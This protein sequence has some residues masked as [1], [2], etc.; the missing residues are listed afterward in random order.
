MQ[1]DQVIKATR[2][3]YHL[4]SMN[5]IGV[6]VSYIGENYRW[7]KYEIDKVA[8][9][10]IDLSS[11]WSPKESQM[12]LV[13]YGDP[14]LTYL[15]AHGYPYAPI[16]GNSDVDRFITQ[17]A[18]WWY[19]AE[20]GI[21]SLSNSFISEAPDSYGLRFH[22]RRLVDAARDMRNMNVGSVYTIGDKPLMACVFADN[23]STTPHII[24]L[25]CPNEYARN[26]VSGVEAIDLASELTSSGSMQSSLSFNKQHH[27]SLNVA[28]GNFIITHDDGRYHIALGGVGLSN[29]QLKNLVDRQIELG[30]LPV[31]VEL[32]AS[33][34]P[35]APTREML[36]VGS[37][38]T[39]HDTNASAGLMIGKAINA[40]S[41]SPQSLE[42]NCSSSIKRV[43]KSGVSNGGNHYVFRIGDKFEG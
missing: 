32:S 43:S 19:L 31:G 40:R 2:S 28:E 29:Q 4:A 37:T 25:V 11:S 12:I 16:Y 21:N 42:K 14:G 23:G 22:I 39:A 26:K 30:R 41:K 33:I 24:S 20:L 7:A 38:A 10:D 15:L 13:G 36:A 8:A 1:W 6:M 34:L 9:Y 27:E 35:S 5:R 3:N 17:A 18:V